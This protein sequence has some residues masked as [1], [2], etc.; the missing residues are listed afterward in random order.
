MDP[1][2]LWLFCLATAAVVQRLAT[3]GWARIQGRTPPNLEARQLRQELAQ[4]QAERTGS[5]GV[6]AA[7]SDRLAF[8]LAH[9]PD[10]RFAT[11]A[12]SYIDDVLADAAANARRRHR[13][14]QEQNARARGE[15][16]PPAE[17][18]WLELGEVVDDVVEDPTDDAT[19]RLCSRC[20]ARLYGFEAGPECGS[21][22]GP[23]GYA[24]SDTQPQPTRPSV[25]TCLNCGERDAPDGVW[26]DTCLGLDATGEE[27]DT[28]TPDTSTPTP[29]AETTNATGGPPT[30]PESTVIDA[31]INDPTGARRFTVANSTTLRDIADQ[32]QEMAGRARAGKLGP[33]AIAEIEGMRGD[34]TNAADKV[35]RVT[36]V[37]T[38]HANA[39]S[40]LGSD[41]DLQDVA[42]GTYTDRN[43]AS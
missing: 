33:K 23:R 3:D 5:P 7:L 21:C 27:D 2:T 17:K 15:E 28:P 37:F 14:R 6:A 43:R 9:P 8:R 18:P 11:E 34:I 30:M 20:H 24:D 16:P 41:E 26:C 4:Q 10:R 40:N 1:I 35:D 39:Q 12:R 29:D 25:P 31:D 32:Y 38:R 36:G 19:Q 13:E 42:T 22:T